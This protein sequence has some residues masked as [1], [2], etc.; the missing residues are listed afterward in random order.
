MLYT[1]NIVTD[2]VNVRLEGTL[3]RHETSRVN[4]GKVKLTGRLELGGVQ[5]EGVKEMLLLHI[6][7]AEISERR[8]VIERS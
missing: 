1:Q 4:P 6:C 5:A 7:A 8:V 2:R 3:I